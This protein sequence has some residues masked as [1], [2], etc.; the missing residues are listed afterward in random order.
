MIQ[1]GIVSPRNLNPNLVIFII[2]EFVRIVSLLRKN[3]D[4]KRTET[5]VMPDDAT[6]EEGRAN[7]LDVAKRSYLEALTRGRE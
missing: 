3:E 6:G 1:T 4:M 2:P 5:T 7:Q